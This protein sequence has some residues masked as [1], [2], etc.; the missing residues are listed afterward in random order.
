M[1]RPRRDAARDAERDQ[2]LMA[3]C[4][5]LAVRARGR[6]SPNPVVGC[7]ITDRRG[8]VIAEAYHHRAGQ[9]HA[10]AL[11]LAQLGGR[12]PGGTLYVN[13]EPCNHH[14]RTPPCAPAV[15]AAGLARVVVGQRDPIRAHAGGIAAL[16]RAGVRVDVGVLEA[17]CAEANR[18]FSTWARTGRPYVVA[19]AALSLDGKIATRAGDSQWITGPAARA[20]GHRLRDQVDAIVVGIGT[21]LADDPQLTTR[22]VRGGRDPIAVVV[23]SQLRTPPR[24]RLLGAGADRRVILATT[25]S[26]PASRQRRLEAAGA[27][28]WRLPAPRRGAS[29]GRVDLRVLLRRLGRAGLTSVLVEGG[30]T[31]H[32]GMIE[33]DLVDELRLYLAPIVVGG[34]APSWVGGAGIT[35]LAAAPR[36]A[37]AGVVEPLAGDR[38]VRL[39]RAKPTSRSRRR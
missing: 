26:A 27:E 16:R 8:R 2:R 5:E 28:V 31:L 36:W 30:G 29:A 25:T 13:L 6:T 14:G 32:A 20:D 12:A 34:P 33:A 38:L 3:R 37:F 19:K 24:A 39:V 9:P 17:A 35:R 4:L 15:A 18:P 21:V 22:G 11:A 1:A 10:E 23:D 7:V